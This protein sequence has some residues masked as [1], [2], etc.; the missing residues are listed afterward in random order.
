[1][2]DVNA[3]SDRLRPVY[4]GRR[5]VGEIP[6]SHWLF[7][8]AEVGANRAIWRAQAWNTLRV[9]ARALGF[10]FISVPLGVFWTAAAFGWLGK[11]VAFPGPGQH[12][13]ALLSNPYLVAAGVALAVAAML[14]IGLKLG[15]V[16]FF[17]RARSALVKEHLGL[18]EPG[19]CSVR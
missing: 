5:F 10:G 19:Q 18:D 12:I 13:G 11:P 3:V 2:S 6:E 1:M 8:M 16:N 9:V 4:I 7:I 14:S 15:Y 17:A